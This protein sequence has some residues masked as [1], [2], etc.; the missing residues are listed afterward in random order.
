MTEEEK[1]TRYVYRKIDRCAIV[2]LGMIFLLF[3]IVIKFIYNL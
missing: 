1:R 3:V 2:A